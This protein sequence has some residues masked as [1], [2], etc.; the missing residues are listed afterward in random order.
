MPED[1]G[2]KSNSKKSSKELAA[3]AIYVWDPKDPMLKKYKDSL[4]AYN[5]GY[6]VAKNIRNILNEKTKGA[7]DYSESTTDYYEKDKLKK[8]EYGK[9][10]K[11][12]NPTGYGK[13]YME[14][15][16]A[17]AGNDVPFNKRIAKELMRLDNLKVKPERTV[18]QAEL[19]D[20]PIYKKPVQ[21]VVTNDAEIVDYS[22]KEEYDKLKKNPEFEELFAPG[23]GGRSLGFVKKQKQDKPLV[24]KSEKPEVK[25]SPVKQEVPAR[26]T[27][28]TGEVKLPTDASIKIEK[29]GGKFAVDYFDVDEKSNLVPKTELFDTADEADSFVKARKEGGKFYGPNITR[30]GATESEAAKKVASKSSYGQYRK[31][32]TGKEK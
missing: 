9:N 19:P 20:L 2:K 12:G 21:R 10:I 13:K 3:K 17:S 4:E 26:D 25:I 28:P 29:R 31:I 18:T 22:T 27:T 24:S 14:A 1:K 5:T 32:G 30:R 15:A 11:G 16:I 23:V 8:P 6:S 7:V